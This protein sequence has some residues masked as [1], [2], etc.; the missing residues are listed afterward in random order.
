M[1]EYDQQGR[2]VRAVTTREAEWTERDRAEILALDLWRQGLCPL[3]GGPLADCTSHEDTGPQFVVHKKRCRAHDAVLTAQA[4]LK[5]T[6]RPG[7][8]L[9]SVSKA[10]AG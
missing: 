10:E 3:H 4:G 9:W 8:L 2:L 7:A 6:L 5:N 1:F